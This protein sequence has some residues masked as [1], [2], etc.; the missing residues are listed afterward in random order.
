MEQVIEV[1]H[2]SPHLLGAKV[3]VLGSGLLT[4]IERDG[5]NIVPALGSAGGTLHGFCVCTLGSPELPCRKSGHVERPHGRATWRSCG[6]RGPKT[7]W[8][9]TEE[10]RLVALLA[11]TQPLPD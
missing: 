1:A 7:A 4:R 8:R 3:L 2:E 10:L 11:L 5:G 6:G 9:R